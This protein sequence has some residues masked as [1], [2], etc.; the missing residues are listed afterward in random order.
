M[1]FSAPSQV[2]RTSELTN[3]VI[4]KSDRSSGVYP[5]VTATRGNVVEVWLEYQ[6]DH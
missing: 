5:E 4:S 2:S 3:A 6:S 1:N